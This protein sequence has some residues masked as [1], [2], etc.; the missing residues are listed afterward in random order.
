MNYQIVSNPSAD[1]HTEWEVRSLVGLAAHVGIGGTAQ[2]FEFR[3][4]GQSTVFPYVFV[5]FGAGIGPM[6]GAGAANFAPPH[7][8]I[9][10]TAKVLGQSLL[11]TAGTLAGSS[12]VE[13]PATPAYANDMLSFVPISVSEPFSAIDLNRSFGQLSVASA[14]L[15]LGYSLCYISAF[16]LN[17]VF[18]GLQST[19]GDRHVGGTT[20]LSLGASANTGMWFSLI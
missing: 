17:K 18:F 20:G 19:S 8:F 4:Q 2:L 14:S 6:L 11:F 9:W 3:R 1:R 13:F 5:G 7:Q 15:A 16:K 10:Q 12:Q